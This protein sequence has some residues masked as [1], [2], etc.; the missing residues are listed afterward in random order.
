MA[1]RAQEAKLVHHAVT[2]P[3]AL[4]ALAGES[5]RLLSATIDLTDLLSVN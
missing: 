1:S 3:S 5:K 4:T 2:S